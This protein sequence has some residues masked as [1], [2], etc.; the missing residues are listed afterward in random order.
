VSHG[1]VEADWHLRDCGHLPA[2]LASSCFELDQDGQPDQNIFDDLTTFFDDAPDAV[3]AEISLLLVALTDEHCVETE[4]W[5]NCEQVARGLFN[6]R[7]RYGCF[8]N[9]INAVAVFDVY[10]A[11]DPHDRLGPTIE[12]LGLLC[13]D[14]GDKQ[15]E[16]LRNRYADRLTAIE[17]ARDKWEPL[18]HTGLSS[19]AVS[20]ALMPQF[21]S[22]SKPN[23]RVNFPR[24]GYSASSDRQ[25]DRRN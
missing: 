22:G 5:S 15:L 7:G 3:R 23:A 16:S 19:L 6:A 12:R 25:A 11:A 4:D 10:F 2:A 24:F 17:Q 1:L 9:L 21:D 8:G 13:A 14:D 20:A 18:R